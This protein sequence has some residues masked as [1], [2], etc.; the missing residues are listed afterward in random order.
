M[1]IDLNKLPLIW[2]EDENGNK[3]TK[4]Y[5]ENGEINEPFPKQFKY[6][7]SK[8]PNE[9]R[10]TTLRLVFQGEVDKCKHPKK[11]IKYEI[12]FEKIEVRKCLKCGGRQKRD[13]RDRGKEWPDKWEGC[14][15]ISYMTSTSSW[16]NELVTKI[17]RSGDYNATEAILIVSSACLRCLNVLYNKYCSCGYKEY[18]DEW[19]EDYNKFNKIKCVL[20]EDNI[21]VFNKL[22]YYEKKD[23]N[24]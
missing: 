20:C 17:V 16:D 19:F 18:S 1:K 4:V 23:N 5:K 21:E 12:H 10:E 22:K 9:I 13:V 6:Q 24:G 3:F 7:C 8:F 2:L 11:S 15:S 14:G